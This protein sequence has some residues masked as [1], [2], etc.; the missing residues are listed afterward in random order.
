[1]NDNPERYQD[2][3]IRLEHYIAASRATPF[4]W[5]RS[6]CLHFAFGVV[7][8]L[9]GRDL[10][11]EMGGS[12]QYAD[13]R[14]GFSQLEKYFGGNLRGIA[15]AVLR[16]GRVSFARRGDIVLFEAR[17]LKAYGIIDNTGRQIA[18]RTESGLAFIPV[19]FA[20]ASWAV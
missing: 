12:G 2:W 3:P 18:A 9:T 11:G 19:R 7:E 17:N 13:A 1:M 14:E 8:P 4:I 16:S 10:I 15:D 20:V 5:G 6:D